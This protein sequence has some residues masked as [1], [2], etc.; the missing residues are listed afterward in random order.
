MMRK[1]CAICGT[2]EA[3]TRDHIPPQGLYPTP[4][5]NDINFNTVPACDICNNGSSSDDEE[6]KVFIG[7]ATGEHQRNP[8]K[9]INSLASTISNNKRIGKNI[10]KTKRNVYARLNGIIFEPAVSITFD[11]K[12][13]D[14][15]ITRIIKGLYWMETGHALPVKSKIT[16]LPGE[17]LE[18]SMAQNLMNLMHA[19]PLR[20]LNK[21]T[22]FYRFQVADDGSS[23]WGLQFFGRHTTFT[24]ASAG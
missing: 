18:V 12:K 11:R 9:V 8:D 3:T 17:G 23:V 4:R 14:R 16:I 13:Y 19:L 6:F 15:V 24:L 20:T 7:I 10:F 22:F 2:N 5:D 1:L 21:D